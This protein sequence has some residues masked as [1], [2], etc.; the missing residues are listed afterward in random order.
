VPSVVAVDAERNFAL[1]SWVEGSPIREPGAADIDE[2]AE[3]LRSL[4]LLRRS[5]PFPSAAL[6]SEACLSAAEIERQI[7]ARLAELRTLPDEPALEAFLSG[8]FAA[9]LAG[10]LQRAKG[11]ISTAG[12]DFDAQLPSGGRSP[13]PSDFGFHNALRRPGGSLAFLDFEYF[14]WDDPV[15]LTADV[16]LHPGSDVAPPLRQSFRRNAVSLYGADDPGFEERLE[17]LQ[18]L[19]GLRWVLILLNEFHPERWRR[20]QL[21]GA[22]EGWSDAKARQLASAQEFLAGLAQ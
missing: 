22:A 1:L 7:R 15:K 14:G 9:G 11:R 4:H 10:A 6:A 21:A 8:G 5:P 18:P 19:F 12:Y 2:A 17:A 13:V 20:R 3:F 16:L